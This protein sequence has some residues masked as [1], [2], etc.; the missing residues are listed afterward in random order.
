M[1]TLAYNDPKGLSQTAKSLGLLLN[2][3][4]ENGPLTFEW[5]VVD[6]SPEVHESV[7][8]KYPNLLPHLQHQ[9][10]KPE[11]IYP[12]MNR[13]LLSARAEVIWFLNSG[14][15][16]IDLAALQEGLNYF[17]KP[18]PPEAVVLG[19]NLVRNQKLLNP[20]IPSMDLKKNLLGVNRICH[21]AVLTQSASFQQHGL[22]ST[23][24][25]IISDYVHLFCAWQ[26]GAYIQVVPKPLVAYD[27][28]GASSKWRASLKEFGRFAWA[29][30]NAAFGRQNWF[31]F[32]KENIRI[33]TGK[34]LTEGPLGT[35]IEP[36]VRRIK[37]ARAQ[38]ASKNIL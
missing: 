19:A 17:L 22:F 2:C 34:L 26:Q 33:R 30:R 14:D 9:I 35:F 18:T 20:M 11:G 16:L 6:S 28:D 15:V 23:D 8:N 27:M 29:N 3:R 12:A 5:R 13:G 25:K 4:L 1:I 31:A 10:E 7:L 37:R 24:Y 36:L 21:Q 32:Q 38:K